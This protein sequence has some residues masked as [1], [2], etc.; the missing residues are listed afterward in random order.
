VEIQ[1]NVGIHS[2]RE[3]ENAVRTAAES[4]KLQLPT[5]LHAR[6]TLEVKA[7]GLQHV[8]EDELDLN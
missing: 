1:P 7:I 2:Q 4:G 3:I 8:I 5:S 6:M